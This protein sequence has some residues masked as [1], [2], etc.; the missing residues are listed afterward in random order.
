MEVGV[1]E[2]SFEEV[3]HGFGHCVEVGLVAGRSFEG[4]AVFLVAFPVG[5]LTVS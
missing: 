2:K 5:N 1:T 4:C 3:A